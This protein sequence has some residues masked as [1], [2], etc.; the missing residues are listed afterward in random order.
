MRAF[1][2]LLLG[3]SASSHA[4]GPE[5]LVI[6]EL[7]IRSA[8]APE[9]I[10]LW[11]PSLVAVDVQGCELVQDGIPTVLS[12]LVVPAQGGMV[13]SDGAACVEFDGGNGCLD[14]AVGGAALDLPD[15]DA[16]TISLRCGGV[17]HDAVSFL[18]SDLST[19]CTAADT[20]SAQVRPEALDAA[21]N[22]GWPAAFC[23]PPSSSNFIDALERPGLGTPGEANVCSQAPCGSGGLLFSEFMVDPP[24]GQREWMELAIRTGCD[25]QGCELREGPFADAFADPSSPDWTVHTIDAPAHTLSVLPG[26]HLLLAADDGLIAGLPGDPGAVEADYRYNAISLGNSEAGW[27]HLVCAGVL[28]DSAPYDWTAWEASCGEAACSINLPSVREDATE[29]DDPT[30]WCLP[31]EAAALVTPEGVPFRGTPG[32]GGQCVSRAWPR[33]GDVIF[34]EL[35]VSPVA[36][37]GGSTRP[38]WVELRNRTSSDFSLD[39]CSLDVMESDDSGQSDETTASR[40]I[41]T[42]NPGLVL[43]AESNLVLSDGSCLDGSTPSPDCPFGERVIEGLTLT[44]D[45]LRWIALVCPVAEGGTVQVDAAP[46][47]LALSNVRSG[48]SLQFPPG[49]DDPPVTND[50]PLQWCEAS[51]DHC[52]VGEENLDCNF[53]TPGEAGPCETGE[54]HPLP[55]APGCRCDN[56]APTALGG[57]TALLAPLLRRRRR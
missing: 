57:L 54:I 15:S 48:H 9:W 12:D 23:L 19:L 8:S 6:S 42:G 30:Q 41:L 13:I 44:N 52:Y 50:D 16:G 47:D 10:E 22:D 53:G 43:P 40:L 35:M 7:M 21:T 34:T 45:E 51:F 36:A 20:C 11:N 26:D 18:W 38:E 27:V 39:G 55:G 2:V 24:G 33:A 25:M 3:A 56:N 14:L 46:W 49:A 37:D 31:P 17:D 5:D 1:A 29:N 4:A 28:V 32:T